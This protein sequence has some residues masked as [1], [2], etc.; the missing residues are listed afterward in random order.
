MDQILKAYSYEISKQLSV[1]VGLIITNCIVMGRAEGFAAQNPPGLSV[2]DAIGNA[3]GY[4]IILI[5]VAT[6]REIFGSGTWFGMRVMPE[7][8]VTNGLALLAPGAFIIIG[9]L[10]WLQR[11]FT[12]NFETD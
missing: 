3:L 9:L 11:T 2:L 5:L 6:V 12:K 1:F 7:G 8:Y 4:S 10:I